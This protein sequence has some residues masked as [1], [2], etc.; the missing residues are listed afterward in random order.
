MTDSDK[1]VAA[2]M[3]RSLRFLLIG[4]LAL[5]LLVFGVLAGAMVAAR[6]G[7]G[8]LRGI[9][10]ALGPVVAALEETDRRAIRADLHNREAL[11]RPSR[12]DREAAMENLVAVLR[13]EPFEPAPLSSLL[14]SLRARA[15]AA[16][17]AGQEALIARIVAMTPQAR[18]AFADRLEAELRAM[19][20][21]R[22]TDGDSSPSLG[23]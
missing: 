14:D 22:R 21:D 6:G 19:P 18:N 5:N 20:G 12:R 10:L 16:Q 1:P 2:P 8:P 13:R 11:P 23:D 15:E 7:G 4:S 17:A 9:D 3:R